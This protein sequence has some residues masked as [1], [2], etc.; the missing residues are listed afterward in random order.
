MKA[1]LDPGKIAIRPIAQGYVHPESN[2]QSLP[3]F[4]HV[5]PSKGEKVGFGA[6]DGLP[7]LP[8]KGAFATPEANKALKSHLIEHDSESDDKFTIPTSNRNKEETIQ[9]HR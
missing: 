2:M 6:P 7:P 5:E 1:E 4:D 9:S 8:Q 3:D